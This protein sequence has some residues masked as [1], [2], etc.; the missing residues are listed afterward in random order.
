[1]PSTPSIPDDTAK[2]RKTMTRNSPPTTVCA[3]CP[4]RRAAASA[5]RRGARAASCAVIAMRLR[6][7]VG[8][9]Q[10][11]ASDLAGVDAERFDCRHDNVALRTAGAD[12]EHDIVDEF[13][14]RPH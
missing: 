10:N 2:I 6:D 9:G 12:N 1:M 4:L 14:K 11:R 8:P 13:G 7:V 3:S 5:L